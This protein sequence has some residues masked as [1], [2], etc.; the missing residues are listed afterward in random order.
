MA[1]NIQDFTKFL[2]KSVKHGSLI[3]AIFIPIMILLDIV[4]FVS[5]DFMILVNEIII[6]IEL[7]LALFRLTLNEYLKAKALISEVK[8][9]IA[10]GHPEIAKEIIK[11]NITQAIETSKETA[12]EI[13]D[14]IKKPKETQPLPED[15]P[16]TESTTPEHQIS[17]R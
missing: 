4:N 17:V 11:D 6:I 9:N 2:S 7:G 12:K 3:I 14:H 13:I 1:L 15:I 16:Q 5:T 10:E 8:K